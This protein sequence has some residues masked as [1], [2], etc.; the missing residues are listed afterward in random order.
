MPQP[1]AS[2]CIPTYNYRRYL[3]EALESALGQTERDLEIVVVDNCSV[4][5]TPELLEAYARR[6]PRILVHRNATNLGMVANFNRCLELARG[7][8]V[9]FL[10]ADD[11]LE[12]TCVEQL[13]A[14]IEAQPGIGLAACARRY[15]RDDG[16]SSATRGYASRQV[17]GGE[18]AIRDCFFRGNLIGEPTAVLLRRS[19]AGRG[20]DAGYRQAF[21]MEFWFRLLEGARL[22]SVETP[23]CRIREHGASGTAE[24]LR[25]GSVSEDKARLFRAYAERPWLR[26]APWERL[27]WDARMASS[28]AREAAA[29]SARGHRDVLDAVYYPGLFGAAT[30]PLVK[31]LTALRF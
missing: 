20:F 1:L 4:D 8:Y 16:T 11:A 25:S 18:A 12:P 7:T 14:A 31:A 3:P 6:D 26:G 27:R 21:D 17:L 5:G 9:K 30:L 13:V 10:C 2:I 19:D 28:V 29:G 24:N 15:F 23:L 22:A